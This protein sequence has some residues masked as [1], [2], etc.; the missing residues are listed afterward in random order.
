MNVLQAG[1][2][3]FSPLFLFRGGS[4]AIAVGRLGRDQPALLE[5][6][7][8]QF[9]HKLVPDL[10]ALVFVTQARSEEHTSELQSQR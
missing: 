1:A 5:Q 7:V 10:I 4:D 8:H 2:S 9:S 6:L 3:R